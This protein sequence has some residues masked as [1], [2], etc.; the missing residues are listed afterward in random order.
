MC[1]FAFEEQSYHS[2]VLVKHFQSH[3]SDLSHFH[4]TPLFTLCTLSHNVVSKKEYIY[5]CINISRYCTK[6]KNYEHNV[7]IPFWLL[8]F[9]QLLKNVMLCLMQSK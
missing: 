2:N 8:Q 1:P 7:H 4:C 6:R 9:V 5:V 3:S